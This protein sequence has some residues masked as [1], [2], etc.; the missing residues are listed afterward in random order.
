MNGNLHLFVLQT[1]V[2]KKQWIK[3]LKLMVHSVESAHKRTKSEFLYHIRGESVSRWSLNGHVMLKAL[4]A[5]FT[6]HFCME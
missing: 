5:C 6:P 4:F 1:C 3:L 2:T